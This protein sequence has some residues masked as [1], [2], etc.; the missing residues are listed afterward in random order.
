MADNSKPND[1]S[2]VN[3]EPFLMPIAVFMGSVIIASS[4]LF[5]FKS[6]DGS[7]STTKTANTVTAPTAADTGDPAAPEDL[8]AV[9]TIDDDPII[10]DKDKA[11]VAIV[12]FSDYECP[13]CKRHHQETM[14][15]IVKNFVDTGKAIYVFRDLP[16]S[17]HEPNATEQAT[18]LQCV[19][20]EYGSKKYYE[21]A[22]KIFETTTS[23]KGLAKDKLVEIMYASG[24][25]QGKFN[26]CFNNQKTLAEV[27]KDAA[28]AAKA[29]ISG[30]PG[31]VVG[32]LDKDGNVDGVKISGAVPYANFQSTI[33]EQLA[34]AN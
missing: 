1:G 28:D 11:K 26:D 31:F 32:V 34:R 8:T 15:E 16:L 18:A 30:T 19:F 7:V 25:D 22:D 27:Q 21:L 14:P 29:G 3:I 9:T 20:S 6:I 24:V 10:G 13:F 23:N 5:G 12:E 33:E 4:I 17:F 2:I